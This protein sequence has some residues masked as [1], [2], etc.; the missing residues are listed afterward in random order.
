L[1]LEPSI[2]L[3]VD[4]VEDRSVTV[5]VLAGD[6]PV[7]TRRAIASALAQTASIPIEVLV[8]GGEPIEIAGSRW[9]GTTGRPRPG[10]LRNLA[11]AAAGGDLI[12]F[13]PTDLELLPGAIAAAVEEH[14]RGFAIV[15]GEVEV[16]DADVW[17]R[18]EHVVAYGLPEHREE[19]T[20][21]ETPG[22]FSSY[23]KS[24]LREY[25]PFSENVEGGE[26]IGLHRRLTWAGYIPYRQSR[27]RARFRPAHPT[28]GAAV[29]RAWR[30]GWAAGVVD[31]ES[32]RERGELMTRVTTPQRLARQLSSRLRQSARSGESSGAPPAEAEPWLRLA[33]GA[34]WLATVA[35][36]SRPEHGKSAVLWGRPVLL[37]ALVLRQRGVVPRIAIVKLDCIAGRAR[38]VRVPAGVRLAD[39][40]NGRTVE[41]ELGLGESGSGLTRFNVRAA[42]GTPLG[43]D[44]E[45]FIELDLDVADLAFEEITAPR[46]LS[47]P[48]GGMRVAGAFGRDGAVR[49]SI[50]RRALLVTALLARNVIRDGD[51]LKLTAD[52]SLDEDAAQIVQSF[53]EE[54]RP[55][56]VLDSRDRLKR[57]NW[58]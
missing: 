54:D 24:L 27:F 22:P 43:L 5:A 12:V 4:A 34:G 56:P 31:L 25:G 6:D 45:D 8:A 2:D 51:E 21:I 18:A 23:R 7:A 15:T 19:A 55:R 16:A 30:R 32:Y 50:D 20:L 10:A 11:L 29:R 58:A 17:T 41:D 33:E 46:R 36:L 28:R 48:A 37:A 52:S 35:A 9:L 49:S 44:L 40:V 53:L 13:L 3:A 47:G 39:T 42:L 57:A 14:A 1:G 26:E 38:V